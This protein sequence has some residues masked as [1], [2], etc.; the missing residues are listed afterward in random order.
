M[1]AAPP[2]EPSTPPHHFLGARHPI[3][4]LR[5]GTGVVWLVNLVFIL[6]PANRFWSTFSSVARSFGASTVGG[7]GLA[8]FVAAHPSIFSWAVAI[9]T[10]YLAVALT[11]G[12]TTRI[13]CFVGG[14]F[15]AMLLATQ[16]GTTFLFP[17]GTDVGAHP[18]YI[19][20]YAVLVVGM[21]GSHLSVD[22]W[23]GAVLSRRRAARPTAAAAPRPRPLWSAAV[24]ARTLAVYFVVG[25][26]ISLG[27][28]LALDVSIP[29]PATSA[30][31]PMTPNAYVNLTVSLNAT[32]GWPQYAPANFS[33]APG[34]IEF[35]ITDRDAPMNWSRCPCPVAGTIGGVEYINGSPYARVPAA[36]VAHTF[37]VPQLGVQ[38][39]SPGGSVV[40]FEIDVTQAGD[41]TWFCL[42]PCGAG[43]DPYSTPPM[44]VPGYMTG[45]MTI[46]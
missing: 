9:T 27:F 25:T 23:I 13:A 41:Y 32:T 14:F 45:T 31:A 42:A 44:G 29:P 39:L 7:P 20:I 1:P 11:L 2:S 43:S 12:L 34:L 37:N 19:L 26:L 33:V 8:D 15:S 4:I 5:I 16:F 38:V 36:N 24:P 35:T 18:L 6:D 30:P 17:G 46:M 22:A 3:E 21:A 10:G 40:Q 28:G